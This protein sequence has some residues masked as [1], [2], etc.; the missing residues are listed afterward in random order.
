[1]LAFHF[2]AIC[3]P[4]VSHSLEESVCVYIYILLGRFSGAHTHTHTSIYIHL[5][6]HSDTAHLSIAITITT[7][8]GGGDLCPL[9]WRCPVMW[10]EDEV[11]MGKKKEKE[12]TFSCAGLITECKYLPLGKVARYWSEREREDIGCCCCCCC[13]L[14]MVWK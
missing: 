5:H 2:T 8:N 14:S 11:E 4:L 13:G 9:S 3:Q 6:L 7:T 10:R 12:S 1:M